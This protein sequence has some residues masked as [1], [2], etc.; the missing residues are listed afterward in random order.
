LQAIAEKLVSSD[1]STPD[2]D[3]EGT[4]MT[5]WSEEPDIVS[6]FSY[7]P[8]ERRDIRLVKLSKDGEKDGVFQIQ[9]VHVPL[10]DA[11]REGYIAVS[12]TWGDLDQGSSIR[13]NEGIMKVR[14]NV[15]QI[16][17]DL[18]ALDCRYVW[19]STSSQSFRLLQ[20]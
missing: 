9:L 4:E 16:L 8:L 11:Q 14:P 12:Y 5:D 3:V 17:H 10:L 19:V 7:S 18:A 6:S 1:L 20:I 13:V 2:I 15:L